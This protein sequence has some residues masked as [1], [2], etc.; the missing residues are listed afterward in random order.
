MIDF[1]NP[2]YFFNEIVLNEKLF[3][4]SDAILHLMLIDN[5]RYMK[6]SYNYSFPE[7]TDFDSLTEEEENTLLNIINFKKEFNLS[8][9]DY[10]LP[11]SASPEAMLRSLALQGLVVYT[12]DKYKSLLEYIIKQENENY[13]ERYFNGR[14]ISI[15]KYLLN[16]INNENNKSI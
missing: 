7:G 16:K 5:K 4:Y 11:H 2:I 12:N 8:S 15:A 6:E 9:N 14:L 10:S 3:K 13:E 1:I